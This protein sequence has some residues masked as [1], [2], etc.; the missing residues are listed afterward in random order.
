M[1]DLYFK[2]S[3]IQRKKDK[4]VA[5]Q[6]DT[7]RG[8]TVLLTIFVIT[9]LSDP[10]VL[11]LFASIIFVIFFIIDAYCT[12][13]IRS[14]KIQIYHLYVE[15]FDIKKEVADITG[16]NLPEYME[17]KEIKYPDEEIKLPIIRYAICLVINLA[18]GI[19]CLQ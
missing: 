13:Q 6:Y 1:N 15:M 5:T 9:Q 18:V 4:A 2:I 12:I 17:D 10:S 7:R 19:I 11:F 14:C 16:R 8:S 3:C